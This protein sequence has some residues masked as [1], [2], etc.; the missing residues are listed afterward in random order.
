M[1]RRLLLSYL[2][3]TVVVL[4][5]LEISLAVFFQQ[6]ELNRLTVDVERDATVLATI[7]E[8]ALE[9]EQ[10]PDPLAAQDYASDT[11]ARVLLVDADGIS[12]IDTEFAVDRDFSTRPE[13]ATALT[14]A[15]STGT[16][17]SETLDTDLLY[18]AV[19]VASGG[20]VHGALRLTLDTHEVTERVWRFWFGLVAVGL[21]VLA[22][23]AGV[24]W[25]IARS[26]T[27]PV[28]RL[29]VAA[30]RFSSG[31]LT[32][33]DV[34]T[35]APVELATLETA[36]NDM[37]RRLDGQIRQQRAFVADASH[38]LRSPLTALRL[39]LENLQ[40]ET[41]DGGVSARLDDS[42]EETNRLSALVNDL[43]QLARSEEA[44]APVTVDLG[45]LVWERVDT[46]S[47]VA[48][49]AEVDLRAEVPDRPVL[50]MAIPGG[51][52]QVLDNLLDNAIR[53][54]PSG[55]VVTAA[56]TMSGHQAVLEVSDVGP[57]IDDADK[58]RALTRFWRSDTSGAGTGLGLAIADSIVRSSGG[59]LTLSDN[60]PDGLVATVVIDAAAQA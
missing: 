36:M 8:D 16:R 33:T 54:A 24:G 30:E 52:E 5:L 53:A 45:R 32:T 28:R 51:M 60:D 34:D 31:D 10:T 39:Q 26:I 3:V 38:Q 56:V 55:T 14:G 29:Q 11:T 6:R 49:Q 43:L 42:I 23:M 2:T 20:T 13:V 25:L 27:R 47:A 50:A 12:L 41:A 18:V 17:R 9:K 46:W 4:L 59:R 35:R 1:T 37:A 15:R 22:V 48:D 44:P 21:V 19:P 7:Y 58:E 40:S 57:G